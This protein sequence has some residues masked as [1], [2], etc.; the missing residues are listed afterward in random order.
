[1]GIKVVKFGGSSL[2]D[3]GQIK[4]A[5]AI[6]KSDEETGARIPGVLFEVRKM[7]GEI[8]GQFTTDRNGVIRLPGLESGWSEV[9]EL[10]AAFGWRPRWNVVEAVRRTVD[11][12]KVWIRDPASVPACMEEQIRAF[13]KEEE[14]SSH[15]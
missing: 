15:V 5:A 12:S 3:A 9:T 1:M 8:V 14:R 4:K 13:F 10:K 6:I 2:A 7:D 11:W